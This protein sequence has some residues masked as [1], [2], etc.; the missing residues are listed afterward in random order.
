MF[1]FGTFPIVDTVEWSEWW[2]LQAILWRSPRSSLRLG[3]EPLKYLERM[4]QLSG[5]ALGTEACD[6]HV[7][8]MWWACLLMVFSLMF[9]VFVIQI[10]SAADVFSFLNRKVRTVMLMPEHCSHKARLGWVWTCILPEAPSIFQLCLSWNFM[11][12]GRF[13]LCD[14]VLICSWVVIPSQ[15]GPA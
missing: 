7:M 15:L 1:L 5:L 10:W 8:S 4:G 12:L 3:D 11:V 13:G 9:S 2:S 14:T 6:E